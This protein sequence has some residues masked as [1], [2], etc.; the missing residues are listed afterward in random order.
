[1]YFPKKMT[2]VEELII[3]FGLQQGIEI[4]INEQDKHR[5]DTEVGVLKIDLRRDQN[6]KDKEIGEKHDILIT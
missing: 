1:M 5:F 4:D 2:N 6:R 3:D